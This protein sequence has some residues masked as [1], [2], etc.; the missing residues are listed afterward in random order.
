MAVTG[1]LRLFSKVLVSNS[2]H[3]QTPN[4]SQAKTKLYYTFSKC[5]P[6]LYFQL[7][8]APESDALCLVR[9]LLCTL[10]QSSSEPMNFKFI[11]HLLTRCSTCLSFPEWGLAQKAVLTLH[12]NWLWWVAQACCLL[13]R[14]SVHLQSYSK[15][16]ASK[17]LA[18]QCSLQRMYLS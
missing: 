12:S 4:C 8:I 5:S 18:K 7:K 3:K 11:W 13:L 1:H 15:M 2:G 10:V 16:W 9:V 6:S 17:G 14:L